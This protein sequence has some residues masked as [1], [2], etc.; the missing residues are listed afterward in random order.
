MWAQGRDL[1][2]VPGRQRVGLNADEMQDLVGFANDLVGA[3]AEVQTTT[4]AELGDGKPRAFCGG[5]SFNHLA[6]LKEYALHL[7]LAVGAEIDVVKLCGNRL[8]ALPVQLG[9]NDVL[10]VRRHVGRF[11]YRGSGLGR[12]VW[13]CR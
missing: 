13:C 8:R 4:K 7:L 2:P 11:T 9:R 10:A 6:G 1:A 3:D 5:C 12:Q